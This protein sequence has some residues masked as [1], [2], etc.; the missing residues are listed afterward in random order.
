MHLPDTV[1]QIMQASHPKP[2]MYYKKDD[3]VLAIAKH[4]RMYAK[5]HP[6]TVDADPPMIWQYDIVNADGQQAKRF[7]VL[8]PR[9][10]FEH[11]RREQQKED[12]H[13]SWYEYIMP[14]EPAF[15]VWDIDWLI[16]EEPE[17][18]QIRSGCGPSGRSI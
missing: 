3:C 10:M 14:E 15:P 5:R 16:K 9:A 4:V 18:G 8:T 12:G 11:L 1:R 17:N 7:T 13:V 6:G 2:V